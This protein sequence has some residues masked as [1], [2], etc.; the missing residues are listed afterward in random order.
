[1]T[2][3]GAIADDDW[4]KVTSPGGLLVFLT[5]SCLKIQIYLCF[6]HILFVVKQ[7]ER[8]DREGEWE[9]IDL[10][11]FVTSQDNSI[12]CDKIREKCPRCHCKTC[13]CHVDYTRLMRSYSGPHVVVHVRLFKL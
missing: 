1:M 10:F 5:I 3:R 6:S 4:K 9:E 7:R 11:F 13:V 2:W 8:V 12:S